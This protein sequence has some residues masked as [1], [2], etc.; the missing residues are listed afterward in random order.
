M[1]CESSSVI[2]VSCPEELCPKPTTSP[3]GSVRD[4]M[5]PAAS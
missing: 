5:L 2:E 4:V 1:V 3:S